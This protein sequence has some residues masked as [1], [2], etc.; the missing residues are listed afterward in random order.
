MQESAFFQWT[1]AQISLTDFFA[2]KIPA[3]VLEMDNLEM[4]KNMFHAGN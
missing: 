2:A 4:E 3:P 1:M